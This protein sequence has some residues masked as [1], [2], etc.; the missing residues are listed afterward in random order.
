MEPSEFTSRTHSLVLQ[1]LHTIADWQV[2]IPWQPFRDGVEIH[3][4]YQ[5]RD[6]KESQASAALLRYQ[7]GATVPAHIHTGYE[8]V[9]VLDGSQ[10]DANGTHK[11]GSLVINPPGSQHDIVSH[12]GCIVLIV[13]EKPVR[14]CQ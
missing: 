8:H 4:L 2:K 5:S 10:S 12:D 3:Y 6:S 1:N 14:L 11:Q 9:L 7:P 13:W